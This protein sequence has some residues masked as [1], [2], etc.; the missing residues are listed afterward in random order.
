MGKNAFLAGLFVFLIVADVS[1]ASWYRVLGRLLGAAPKDPATSPSPSPF[2]DEKK[3]DPK[4]TDGS[5]KTNRS[6]RCPT[7]QTRWIPRVIPV[8]I[9]SRAI[10]RKRRALRIVMGRWLV[11]RTMGR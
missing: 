6:L 2:P 5:K 9:V 10:I 7:N 3:S 11:A 4:L 8:I 1:D